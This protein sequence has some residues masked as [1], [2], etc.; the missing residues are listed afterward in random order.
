[1]LRL[2]EKS[3]RDKSLAINISASVHNAMAENSPFIKNLA[4]SG[5]ITTNFSA[6][7]GH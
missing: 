4:S 7:F 1:V 2:P 3:P 6:S 5:K